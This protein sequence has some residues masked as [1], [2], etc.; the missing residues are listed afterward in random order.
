MQIK[1]SATN[2]SNHR[3]DHD[4]WRW[5]FNR[6]F[7]LLE[8]VSPSLAVWSLRIFCV[9]WIN[10]ARGSVWIWLFTHQLWARE[11]SWQELSLINV[12]TEKAKR[13]RLQRDP[14]TFPRS[15]GTN[16]RGLSVLS[17]QIFL[18]GKGKT[19]RRR[20]LKQLHAHRH[21][22]T[23]T[24][25]YGCVPIKA[26]LM[27]MFAPFWRQLEKLLNQICIAF[28]WENSK[29]IDRVFFVEV[30]FPLLLSRDENEI[31]VNE[32][33]ASR[34]QDG[35]LRN[36]R[37]CFSAAPSS[38]I[39]QAFLRMIKRKWNMTKTVERKKVARNIKRTHTWSSRALI[40]I[41]EIAVVVFFS[42]KLDNRGRAS[43]ITLENWFLPFNWP[44]LVS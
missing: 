34:P 29:I 9:W 19:N 1:D 2:I 8:R 27:Q 12:V 5:Q 4:Q 41:N 3:V 32:L 22:D 28:H 13:L 38:W 33:C 35:A 40:A 21:T 17:F 16:K 25:T 14:S 15:Q 10:K 30:F 37:R 20:R 6:S 11:F 31:V 23:R 24:P 36:A 26:Q 44:V 39:F 18:I 43:R 42:K 7:T